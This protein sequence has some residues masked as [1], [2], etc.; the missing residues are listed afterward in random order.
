[1]RFG[2]VWQATQEASLKTGPSPPPTVSTSVKSAPVLER[3]DLLGA[4]P[5][6]WIAKVRKSRGR[7]Q[8]GS[9]ATGAQCGH[10]A[11][12]PRCDGA[13][14]RRA[15]PAGSGNDRQTVH[16]CTCSVWRFACARNDYFKF[17][18]NF[19]N[20]VVSTRQIGRQRPP[21]RPALLCAYDGFQ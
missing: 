12:P 7:Q 17:T 5:G 21:S 14:P 18:E 4:E 3:R 19:A 2:P 11:L 8:H 9:H 10:G 1:A 13:V 15:H 6:K 20:A 16:N